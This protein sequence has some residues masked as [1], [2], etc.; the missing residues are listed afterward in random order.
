MSTQQLPIAS[1]R[2][3]RRS[4]TDLVRP[5]WKAFAATT[6]LTI[7]GTIAAAAGPM[8][9]GVMVDQ[10]EGNTSTEKLDLIA[11]LMLGA[12]LAYATFQYLARWIASRLGERMG[13]R[14]RERFIKRCL[15]LPLPK[16]ERAG[17]GDLTVRSSADVP[18]AGNMLRDGIPALL[19]GLLQVVV[20]FGALIW[21]SPSL[22]LAFLLLLPIVLPTVIWYLRRAHRAFLD[23]RSAESNI[24]EVMGSTTEGARTVEAYGLQRQRKK[25]RDESILQHWSASRFVLRVQSGFYPTLEASYALPTAGAFL[26]GGFLYFNGAM[27]LG[28][29]VAAVILTRQLVF[30]IDKILMWLERIQRGIAAF[31]RVEGVG[32]VELSESRETSQIPNDGRVVMNNLCFSYLKGVEVLHGINLEIEPGERLAIVGPSGAGKSTI[33]RLIC[34][35]DMPQSGTVTIG[36]VDVTALPLSIRRQQISLVTQDHHVFDASVRENL[37]LAS[38]DAKDSELY[39]ALDLVGAKWIHD[40]NEGLN[41]LIGGTGL[42]LDPSK[43]QQLSLAR[44]V[45]ADPQVV[46]LDEATAML[47]PQAAR[48]T[49]RS[50][51]S[52]LHGRTV[53]AIAH[54]LH[55]AH[56]AD[57]VVVMNQG[58]IAEAGSHFDL[59]AKNGIYANLWSAWHGEAKLISSE[60]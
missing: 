5:E 41:T 26:L 55:T 56:D 48:D 16:I 57:R 8:L 17:S 30:P 45:L 9:L 4:F 3:L 50:L 37:T 23:E 43:A 33:A 14:M 53:I 42:D 25:S 40:L 7:L 29:V 19:S 10:L 46:I 20:L 39:R 36:G 49:E 35:A 59:I 11:L 27:S 52:V 51:A 22:S 44:V 47:D 54:R 32:L 15:K 31:A 18:E 2:S 60:L 1:G 34:G 6:A 21:V 58:T 38:P 13:A 24:G 12:V 28:V